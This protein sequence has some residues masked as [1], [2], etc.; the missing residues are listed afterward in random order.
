MNEDH[1]VDIVG[2]YLKDKTIA[3]CVTGGIAAIESPKIARQ[4]RRYGAEVHAYMTGEAQKFV[5][6]AALE[7]GTGNSVVTELS[8]RSEHIC[9]EDLVLVAPA[10]TN[11]IDKI[12]NGIADNPVTTLVASALGYQ[13]PVYLAPTMHESLYKNP[14]LQENLKRAS[15]YGINIIAPRLGEGKAKM[16]KLENLV[17]EVCRELSDDPLKGKKILVTAGPTPVKIDAVR[18][19]TNIFTG[20]LGMIVANEA[21]LRGADPLLLLGKTGLKVPSYLP[22]LYHT[23]FDQYVENVFGELS[24]GYDLGIFSA[25]VADY[26][27]EVVQE[28]KI[29]SQG[30]LKEIKMIETMKVIKAVREKY[31]ELYMVTF[32]Y[33]TGVS[34]DRL[35][36]IAN[37]RL[38]DYQLVVANRDLDMKEGKHEAYIV[39]RKGVLANPQTKQEIA[40]QLMD[41]LGKEV[42]KF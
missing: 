7:W 14:F 12:F 26:R 20:K 30:H 31:P 16:P 25:A 13:T 8:G 42:G 24:K 11:T 10:T 1:Q 40:T 18:R 9:R 17:A 2:D 39:G 34:V 19:I 36:E 21:Y 27:P 5:G 38:K 32:K 33:E 29:P 35:M 3:L 28:G 37:S 41:V 6:L 15:D 22:T 4:L 23:D